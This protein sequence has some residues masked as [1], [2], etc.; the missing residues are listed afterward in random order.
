M[1][2][3]MITPDHEHIDSLPLTHSMIIIWGGG[4]L[5]DRCTSDPP[6]MRWTTLEEAG[7]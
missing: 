6:K 5:S 7:K 4:F 2:E 1:L 3:D